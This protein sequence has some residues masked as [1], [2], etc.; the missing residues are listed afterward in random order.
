MRIHEPGALERVA[1]NGHALGPDGVVAAPKLDEGEED[2]VIRVQGA[3]LE[4]D[5]AIAV[6]VVGEETK[7]GVR[8]GEVMVASGL[9]QW[10]LFACRAAAN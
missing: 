7:I 2:V 1:D 3:F 5:A 9:G 10:R 4:E 8:D 6:A